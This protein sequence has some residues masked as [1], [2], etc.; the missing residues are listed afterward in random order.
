MLPFVLT[1]A[2]ATRSLGEILGEMLPAGTVLLLQGTLGTGKTTLVQG[3][4]IG[5]GI[6]DR[7]TSPTFAIAHEYPEGRVPLYH[8]DLYR[9]DVEEIDRLR[10]DL[11]WESGEVEP[12]IVAIEWAE[13]LRDHPQDCLRIELS[14]DGDRRHVQFAAA[15]TFDRHLL[16]R[17]LARSGLASRE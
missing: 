5:L 10:L 6:A 14:H 9:L 11:Y 1:D 13:K 17:V 3:L 8:F 15:G 12:G 16:D 4:G 2:S 7:V